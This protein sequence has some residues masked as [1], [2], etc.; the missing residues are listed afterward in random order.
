MKLAIPKGDGG[1][2]RFTNENLKVGDKVFPLVH[3]WSH[4]G[5]WYL[6]DLAF[7]HDLNHDAFSIFACTGWRKNEKLREPHTIKDFY[8]ENGLQYVHTDKGYSPVHV[9]FK[10]ITPDEDKKFVSHRVNCIECKFDETCKLKTT[11]TDG[12]SFYMKKEWNEKCK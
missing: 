2:Y 1:F 3:G 11:K 9:Y 7:K 10:D 4:K 8:V 12:C 5:E 6:T